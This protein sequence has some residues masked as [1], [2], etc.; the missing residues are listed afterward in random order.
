MIS[1]RQ[2]NINENARLKTENEI[3]LGIPEKIDNVNAIIPWI[4]NAIYGVPYLGWILE[5]ILG[6]K[7]SIDIAYDNR[8]VISNPASSEPDTD[9][10]APIA[11]IK[12]PVAPKI[13]NATSTRG[14][15]V[16]DKLDQ[17]SVP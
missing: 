1:A 12:A 2:V 8:A 14:V 3:N 16:V 15:E 9:N 17:L 6:N 5:N 4:I 13:T 7:P 11:I 10:K